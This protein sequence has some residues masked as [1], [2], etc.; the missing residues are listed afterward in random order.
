MGQATDTTAQTSS[1]TKDMGGNVI[2]QQPRPRYCDDL[3]TDD[4]TV[5]GGSPPLPKFQTAPSMCYKIQVA[6]LRTTDPFS[7]PF[8]KDLVARWRP[9]EQVW[10]VES[11]E[12]YCDRAEAERMREEFKKM[13]YSG[14]YL[15]QLVSYESVN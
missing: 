2:T 15:T 14:A 8:H 11:K 13:G 12:S 6:I 3:P 10:V 7:Y 4:L 9:C 1:Q 5:K